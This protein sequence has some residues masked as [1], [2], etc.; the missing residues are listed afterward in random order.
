MSALVLG[1]SL[2]V[3]AGVQALVAT[4]ASPRLVRA[5]AVRVLRDAPSRGCGATSVIV[6]AP[7]TSP[8]CHA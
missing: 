2:L 1:V 6:A 5:V 4:I 3:L 7:K 8:P